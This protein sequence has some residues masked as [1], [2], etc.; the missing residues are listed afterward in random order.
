MPN[1]QGEINLFVARIIFY[2][3]EGG[4]I[5]KNSTLIMPN[6]QG[7]INLF[8]ARIIFYEVISAL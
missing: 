1:N 3:G 8:V 7:E 5:G 4:R 2:V 6:N